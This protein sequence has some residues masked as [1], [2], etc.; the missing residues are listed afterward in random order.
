MF[1]NLIQETEKQRKK[2]P[3]NITWELI[4]RKNGKRNTSSLMNFNPLTKERIET[5]KQCQT[6][7]EERE[8][9]ILKIIDKC[10]DDDWYEDKDIFGGDYDLNEL[11]D[12]TKE[13]IKQQ[14]NPAKTK[15]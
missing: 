13:E 3:L 15:E 9:E 8:K 6:I 10:C 7:A 2:E 5:L 11:I 14:L 1:E 12:M 4:E